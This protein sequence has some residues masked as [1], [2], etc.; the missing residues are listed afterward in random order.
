MLALAEIAR[1]NP[2]NQTLIGDVGSGAVFSLVTLLLYS[3]SRRIEMQC[4]YASCLACC[5][6][7]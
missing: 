7:K 3:K 2:P 4:P 6:S 1:N 5:P